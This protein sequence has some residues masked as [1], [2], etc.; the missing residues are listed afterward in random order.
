MGN[1]ISHKCPCI[2]SSSLTYNRI[3]PNPFPSPLLPLLPPQ[4]PTKF[5]SRPVSTNHKS[6]QVNL[7]QSQ[8]RLFS[9]PPIR[10]QGGPGLI[11]RVRLGG[12]KTDMGGR[13]EWEERKSCRDK[14]VGEGGVGREEETEWRCGE[15]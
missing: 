6:S 15:K 8:M 9:R 13:P 7:S 10:T 11:A 3:F 1:F 14:P 2:I 12:Y 5:S 4:M